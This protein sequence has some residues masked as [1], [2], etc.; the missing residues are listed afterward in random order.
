MY[1]DILNRNSGVWKLAKWSCKAME[2]KILAAPRK[3]G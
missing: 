2:K 1:L 3:I